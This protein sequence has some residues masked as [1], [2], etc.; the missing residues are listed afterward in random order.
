MK[1]Q[2]VTATFKDQ[3]FSYTAQIP[4]TA[5]EFT[6]LLGVPMLDFANKEYLNRLRGN[7]KGK[8]KDKKFKH[9][10][11][12]KI[13]EAVDGFKLRLATSSEAKKELKGMF[14]GMSDA[15]A[16]AAAEAVE[17]LRKKE[18]TDTPANNE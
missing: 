9:N 10:Q 1:T 6:Q 5:D 12:A 7:I 14:K 15:E 4:E 13:Q 11:K 16:Q 8:L 17:K 3:E 18:A 2:Q